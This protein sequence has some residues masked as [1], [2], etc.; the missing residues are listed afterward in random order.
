[1]LKESENIKELILHSKVNSF[2]L[3]IKLV[4]EDNTITDYVLFKTRKGKLILQKPF[5]NRTVL[6]QE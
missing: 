1:M 3:K 6:C 2:P 4:G 5:F